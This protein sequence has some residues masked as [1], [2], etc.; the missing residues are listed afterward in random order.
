MSF[1]TLEK[2]KWEEEMIKS[3][4]I[5]YVRVESLKEVKNALRTICLERILVIAYVLNQWG[6]T[7]AI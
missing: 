2:K 1:G 6:R 4:K 5:S 3:S 7:A